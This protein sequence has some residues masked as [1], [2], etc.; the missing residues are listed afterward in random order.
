MKLCVLNQSVRCTLFYLY[1]MHCHENW[2]G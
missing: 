1:L 2:C